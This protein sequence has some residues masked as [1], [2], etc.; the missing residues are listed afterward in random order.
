MKI[1]IILYLIF[2]MEIEKIEAEHYYIKDLFSDKFLFEIPIFQRPFSWEQDN[3]QQLFDDINDAS[4]ENLDEHGKSNKD[5]EPYFLGAIILWSQE[6]KNDESG[7]YA[8]ID[9]QQRLISLAIL[10]A[11]IRDITKSKEIHDTMQDYIYQKRNDTK[12]TP[13]SIRIS[14]REKEK[15]IFEK[16]VLKDGGTL[17]SEEINKVCKNQSENNIKTA[18][19]VFKKNF[20]ENGEFNQELITKF[21]A[22]LS[23]KV[24][25]VIVKSRNLSSAFR[26]F[27]VINTRGMKLTNADLLKSNAFGNIPEKDHEKYRRTWEDIEEGMENLGG[28]DV[29]VRFIR[30]IKIKEKARKSIYEEYEKKIFKKDPSFQGENFIKY[31]ENVWKIYQKK[32]LDAKINTENKV[33]NVK[34]YNLMSLMRD[35]I[36]WNDWMSVIIRFSLKFSD[37]HLYRFLRSFERKIT[38]DW[39][40]GLSYTERL[41]QTFKIITLIESTK[42]E[43]ELIKNPIFNNELNSNKSSFLKQIDE[44][45]FYLKD[46]GLK[47]KFILLGLDMWE[48]D[49]DN[50][51]ISYDGEI[52]LEHILPR[53]P[54][55]VYWLKRFNETQRLNWTNRLGNLVLLDSRKNSSAGRRPFPKKIETYI[56]KKKGDFLI[57]DEITKIMDWNM[58]ELEKRHQSLKQR[59]S[60][61]WFPK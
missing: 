40:S 53:N 31:L 17:E 6:I 3:F 18:I 24:V 22:Y 32:I 8:V 56:K 21:S 25:L 61:I 45:N 51:K 38:I 57:T 29:L 58:K 59:I 2:I 43:L 14:I 4:I 9:G 60:K 20:R 49:Q 23:Q 15:D 10:M 48:R 47:A 39:I 34:Y 26:L 41:T 12:G 30:N 54:D 13:E 28:I 16:F 7:R 27:N 44:I 46:H 1:Y 35:F 50:V 55:D 36:P 5:Y 52:S 42:S 37:N 19:N 33:F 11:I